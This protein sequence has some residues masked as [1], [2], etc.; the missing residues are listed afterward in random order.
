MHIGPNKQ[1]CHIKKVHEKEMLTAETQV[2]LGD[3]IS[4]TGY[5]D[6]NIKVRCQI[7]H[8]AISQIQSMLS[9]GVFGKFTMQTGLNLR[10]TNFTSKM[11]LNS[12]VW[13][14][15]T[16]A[17]VENLEIVDR[18]LMRKIFNA[19]CKT[20]R[21]WLYSDAGK[22]DLKSLIQIRRLMYLWEILNRDKSEL[23]TRIYTTQKLIN[24]TGDWVRLVD[25][26]KAEL[27]II[28]TDEEIQGVSKLSFKSFVK[29][30]V[31][32]NY[33]RNLSALKE[34]HSKSTFVNTSKLK[35]ADY[36]IS[37]LF[38]T[39][40]KQLLFKRRSRTLDVKQNFPGQFSS[41]WCISCGLFQET[42]Q[43]LLHCPEIVSKLSYLNQNLSA[44][45]ED[46]VYGSIQQQRIIVNIYSDILEVR[47][48]LKEK[49]D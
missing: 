13:H 7:G 29:K 27:G 6:E 39:R 44:I 24:S 4:S 46:L 12:E 32:E 16:K 22:L 3:T 17:Q 11:L 23:I 21:E 33:L 45:S 8:S 40:E 20:S 28:I 41:P 31:T 18:I 2:Y 34:K 10:D 35:V 37:P 43:H 36:I 19:H 14:S 15:V 49:S 9:D 25:A 5:N 47:E 30:K 38:S 48:I 42:Q 1:H 26:D